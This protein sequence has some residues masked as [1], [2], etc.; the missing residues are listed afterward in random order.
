MFTYLNDKLWQKT[1]K[2][3]FQVLVLSMK[4]EE[5]ILLGKSRRVQNNDQDFGRTL[6]PNSK[7]PAAEWA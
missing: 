6:E 2:L 4:L 1:A 7:N 3:V 5:Y